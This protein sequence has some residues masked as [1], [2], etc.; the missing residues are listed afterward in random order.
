MSI[1]QIEWLLTICHILSDASYVDAIRTE[2]RILRWPHKSMETIF[3][4]TI[5]DIQQNCTDFYLHRGN[6]EEKIFFFAL[7]FDRKNR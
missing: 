5:G 4:G 1:D 7:M 2:P 3:N 6:G